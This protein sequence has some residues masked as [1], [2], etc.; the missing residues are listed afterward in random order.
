MESVDHA[1][2]DAH[3]DAVTL[4]FAK[5]RSFCQTQAH[6]FGQVDAFHLGFQCD[7]KVLGFWRHPLRHRAKKR[8]F[9][10]VV[11]V[12]YRALPRQWRGRW[13]IILEF[14]LAKRLP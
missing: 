5:T 12:T 8:D 2:A 3:A 9:W 10:G 4:V 7:L 13:L 1:F 11:W 14:F 6:F